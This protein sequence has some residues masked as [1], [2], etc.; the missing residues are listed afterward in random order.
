MFRFIKLFSSCDAS[1]VV[2]MLRE[3]VSGLDFVVAVAIDKK[4][5][6]K[7]HLS[8]NDNLA[9]SSISSL[10][11]K[12]WA[13]SLTALSK[14][15]MPRCATVVGRTAVPLKSTLRVIEY[16]V[17]PKGRGVKRCRATISPRTTCLADVLPTWF[18][19]RSASSSFTDVT[20]R[21]IDL[22]SSTFQI[23]RDRKSR[24][25]RGGGRELRHE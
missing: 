15:T 12:F 25:A 10:R 19:G 14:V 13:A 2:G 17:W 7:T 6:L 8:M 1:V 16:E 5:K 24:A 9:S 22:S 3:W 4:T 21:T 20:I 11:S 23:S 18:S